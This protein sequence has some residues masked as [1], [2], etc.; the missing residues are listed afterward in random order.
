V[1]RTGET[2]ETVWRRQNG[3]VSLVGA[4][5]DTNVLNCCILNL[6]VASVVYGTLLSSQLLL[7]DE[8]G[9]NFMFHSVNGKTL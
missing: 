4:C 7:H 2:E 1:G 8:T 9:E 3:S 6:L 5:R